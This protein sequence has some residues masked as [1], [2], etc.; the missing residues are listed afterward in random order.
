M[1]APLSDY[2]CVEVTS[3]M[4]FQSLKVSLPKGQLNIN[5]AV[6]Q[7]NYSKGSFCTD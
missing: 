5:I 1:H 3:R 2:R 4:K 6:P 7:I